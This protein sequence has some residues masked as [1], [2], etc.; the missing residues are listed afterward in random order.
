MNKA[1]IDLVAPCGIYCGACPAYVRTKSCFGCRPE[2]RSQKRISKWH[3]KIRNC[4]LMDKKL[5][6]CSQCADFPC[7]TLIKLKE[8]HP[9]DEKFSYR[10]EIIV[11]LLRMKEIGVSKWLKEREKKWRCPK[12]GGRAT[13]YLYKCSDCGE[14]I[15]LTEKLARE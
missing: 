7:K 5:E 15:K 4:C 13:F 14:Q 8:S 11:G 1:E 2:D 9:G 10:R 3:C 6:F 12:C